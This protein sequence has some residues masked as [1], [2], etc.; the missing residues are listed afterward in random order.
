MKITEHPFLEDTCLLM[1]CYDASVDGFAEQC[2]EL[3]DPIIQK[4]HIRVDKR[5]N[6]IRRAKMLR[7]CRKIF[8]SVPSVEIRDVSTAQIRLLGLFI[9]FYIPKNKEG[10]M[11]PP[12]PILLN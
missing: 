4:L 7:T 9:H 6:F 12:L 5:L 11:T 1:I 3:Y 2:R 8:K 10:G